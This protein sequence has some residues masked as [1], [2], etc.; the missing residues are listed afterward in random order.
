MGVIVCSRVSAQNSDI[1]L[2]IFLPRTYIFH[3]KAGICNLRE[4]PLANTR[5]ISSQV[6]PNSQ[7][8]RT[9]HEAIECYGSVLGEE[10][11]PPSRGPNF[12][13]RFSFLFLFRDLISGSGVSSGLLV[14][15]SR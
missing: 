12:F 11:G 14:I 7:I 4:T 3:G 2:K 1:M 9:T 5:A 8:G 13:E 15:G 10:S 6:L